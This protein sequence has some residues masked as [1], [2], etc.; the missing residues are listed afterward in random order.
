MT[1]GLAQQKIRHSF[2]K[3]LTGSDLSERRLP[4][5]EAKSVNEGPV[6]WLTACAHGDEVSG[7]VVIQEVFR[8][9]QR[10]PLLKGTIFALPLMNP[11][12]FETKTREI[13]L[14]GQDLNRAYPGDERGSLAERISHRIFTAIT[15]TKPDLVLDFHNLWKRSIPYTI[16]D[17]YPGI[18]HRDVYMRAKAFAKMSGFPIVGEQK[19]GMDAY[20]WNNTLSG[21]LMLAQVPALSIEIGE[22]FIVNETLVDFALKSLWNI[23]SS[24][25]MISSPGKPFHYD[26]PH[27][28]RGKILKY[29]Q[30]PRTSTSGVIRFLLE[31]GMPVSKGQPVAKIYNAFGERLET[32]R[33]LSDGLVLGHEES[34]VGFPGLPIM[35]FGIIDGQEGSQVLQEADGPESGR[36]PEG[37]G[38]E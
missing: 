13:P 18:R 20:N 34:S 10:K 27:R 23:L 7:I 4:L 6:I 12:G 9:I 22:S 15:S 11:I 8:R 30:H 38:G 37:V 14:S 5:M 31:P 16:L 32:L 35:S 3:I 25:G 1:T 33:S 29:S 26:V 28:F 36:M 2:I 21:S 24:L 19:K 17:P